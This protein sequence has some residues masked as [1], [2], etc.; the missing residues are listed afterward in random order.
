MTKDKVKIESLRRRIAIL[1]EELRES[2]SMI[3]AIR[4]GE[5]DAFAINAD[6]GSEVRTLYSGDHAYRAMVEQMGESALNVSSEGDILFANPHFL[7]LTGKEASEVIGSSVFDYIHSN[8]REAFRKMFEK[9]IS[10][11][12]KGEATLKG[13][14]R[15][16]PVYLS[17]TSLRPQLD[18]VGIVL[19]DL[20]EVKAK[21]KLIL[22]YQKNLQHKNEALRDANEELA[23]FVYIASH[24]LQ[25]PLRKIQTFIS[26]IQDREEQVL[27]ERG[28][29]YFG[30]IDDA[31]SR[32][33]N[34]IV[35]LL[36]YSRASNGSQ[37]YE[38]IRVN[39]VLEETLEELA[40]LMR[41]KNATV[42]AGD[43][44]ELP[45][46]PFQFRQLLLNLVGNSIKFSHPDR[47]PVVKVQ[48]RTMKEPPA[49]FKDLPKAPAYY[50]LV[51]SDNG[52]G[53][54]PQYKNRIF[55]LFQRLHNRKDFSGTG[56]GLA[57]V[58]KILDAHQGEIKATST[59]G[60]GSEFS[61]VLPIKDL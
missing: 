41:E 30:R 13:G 36:A 44:G 17:M 35:D 2:E 4:S 25:E 40:E 7:K 16:I 42:E 39:E 3:N 61:L 18:T 1:E 56:I 21:E 49:E 38:M 11:Q 20:S 27:S 29:N 47:N 51:I 23:S 58:K 60:S 34:L 45:A 32:M 55:E 52:I 28:K 53:F 6:S 31:A 43:L 10:G 50:S 54:E 48:G 37:E 59:P 57:I 26:R 12:A 19:T 15:K 46:I 8:S 5:V 22:R 14:R 24:D 33:K 9:S